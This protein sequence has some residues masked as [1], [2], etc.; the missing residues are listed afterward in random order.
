[1]DE[2]CDICETKETMVAIAV[3]H[4][5]RILSRISGGPDATIRS[6]IARIDAAHPNCRSAKIVGEYT[7]DG[8]HH[9]V[10]MGRTLASREPRTLADGQY[11]S[12]WIVE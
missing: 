1:M 8:T 12:G 5:G 7:S 11:Y 10:G 4:D 6:L 3:N 2:M 9:G